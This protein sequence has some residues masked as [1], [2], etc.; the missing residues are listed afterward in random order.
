V[1]DGVT[2]HVRWYDRGPYFVTAGQPMALTGSLEDRAG[3]RLAAARIMDCI[4]GLAE[5]S[6][7][8]LR[9]GLCQ[10][11]GGEQGNAPASIPSFGRI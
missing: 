3:V 8:R 11:R 1:I 6:A 5:Q 7:L 2:E 4:A 10:H 9:S